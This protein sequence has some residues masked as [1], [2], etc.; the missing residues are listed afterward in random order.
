MQY[1]R[2]E[3]VPPWGDRK[4][5]TATSAITRVM[6]PSGP[7]A[8]STIK[9][10]SAGQLALFAA[11]C[12]LIVLPALSAPVTVNSPCF[13]SCTVSF[14]GF[15]RDGLAV[16]LSFIG[17]CIHLLS[18]RNGYA[19]ENPLQCPYPFTLEEGRA[20]FGALRLTKYYWPGVKLVT[21][22]SITLAFQPSSH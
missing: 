5:M 20:P 18:Y 22:K 11:I 10:T 6:D 8:G 1:N 7:T 13:R 14:Y 15:L 19:I 16:T 9:N 21:P 12:P 17:H 2:V 4:N 3:M